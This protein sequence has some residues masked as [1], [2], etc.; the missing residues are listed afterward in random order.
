MKGSKTEKRENGT[1]ELI[2]EYRRPIF[3]TTD[4]DAEYSSGTLKIHTDNEN[5]MVGKL[6]DAHTMFLET[7]KTI[8]ETAK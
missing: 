7:L 6:I 8:G 4:I 2:L 1:S 3:V 5:E